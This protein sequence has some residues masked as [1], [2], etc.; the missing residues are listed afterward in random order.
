M[1]IQV[2]D[3]LHDLRMDNIMFILRNVFILREE[4]QTRLSTASKA[5]LPVILKKIRF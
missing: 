5:I 2:N 1:F 4:N 3:M